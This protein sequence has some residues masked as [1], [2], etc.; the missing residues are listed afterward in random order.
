MNMG[1]NIQVIL[2]KEFKI[3]TKKKKKRQEGNHKG[4]HHALFKSSLELR[5]K[6]H[7][8][9]LLFQVTMIPPLEGWG[10]RLPVVYSSIY[11][12]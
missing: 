11:I 2:L 5:A 4:T 9:R 10:S 7:P 12:F 1:L 3:L 6:T 8:H